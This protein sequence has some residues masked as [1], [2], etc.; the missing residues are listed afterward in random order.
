MMKYSLPCKVKEMEAKTLVL[1]SSAKHQHEMTKF[2]V[3]VEREHRTM[4]FL[5]ST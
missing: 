2:K 5:F 4:N 1:P 3:Y